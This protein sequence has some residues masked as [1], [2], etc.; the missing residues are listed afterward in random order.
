MITLEQMS[1]FRHFPACVPSALTVSEL[2]LDLPTDIVDNLTKFH[3]DL[4]DRSEVPRLQI[5]KQVQTCILT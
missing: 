3:D 1:L 4:M 2:T 5:H